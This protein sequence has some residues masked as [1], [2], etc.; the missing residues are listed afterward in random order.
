MK[1]I[2]SGIYQIKCLKN[3]KIYIGETISFKC[4]LKSHVGDLEK[5]MHHNRDLQSDFSLF[6]KDNF[7]FV[8]LERLP[9]EKHTLLNRENHYINKSLNDGEIL[10]NKILMHSPI[11]LKRDGSVSRSP[12]SV[13]L[14]KKEIE[15]IFQYRL[16]A[17]QIRS[18]IYIK[19]TGTKTKPEFPL[20]VI[21][22]C[23][24]SFYRAR[25]ALEATPILDFL[26]G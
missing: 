24:R 10:Y 15:I 13:A 25:R 19:A 11:K 5:G 21:G 6:G 26:G 7:E 20:E 8:V 9:G 14:T 3:N 23:R 16:S 1:Y 17:A 2:D 12:D 4:R 22:M 18:F